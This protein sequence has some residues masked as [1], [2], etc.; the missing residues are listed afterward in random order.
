MINRQGKKN[1]IKKQPNPSRPHTRTHKVGIHY[2]NKLR[3]EKGSGSDV[4]S[5]GRIIALLLCYFT[6][7]LNNRLGKASEEES[8]KTFA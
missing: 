2:A 5:V 7:G 4:E 3:H 1:K 8:I 6:L